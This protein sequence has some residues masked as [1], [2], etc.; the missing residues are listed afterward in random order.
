[1]SAQQFI[2]Q[3]LTDEVMQHR[4]KQVL[5]AQG[6]LT[7]G[8]WQSVAAEYGYYFSEADFNAVFVQD[9]SLVQS[10]MALATKHQVADLVETEYELNELELEMIAGGGRSP[11]NTEATSSSNLGSANQGQPRLPT[12]LDIAQNLIIFNKGI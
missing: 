8:V 1:M 3:L 9:P 2:A 7:F 4:M 11:C 10:L 12:G 5:Q 6:V